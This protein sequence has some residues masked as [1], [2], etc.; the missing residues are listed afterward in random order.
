MEE[1][2]SQW[3]VHPRDMCIPAHI[4]VPPVGIHK[5][6]K[7]C[8]GPPKA[9]RKTWRLRGTDY[10]TDFVGLHFKVSTDPKYKQK[11]IRMQMNNIYGYLVRKGIL[12]IR[13]CFWQVSSRTTALTLASD[14]NITTITVEWYVCPNPGIPTYHKTFACHCAYESYFEISYLFEIALG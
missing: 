13:N 8:T 12:L 6:L 1:R 11:K 4:C 14:T 10:W 9:S 2:V 5:T 3:Y 7:L